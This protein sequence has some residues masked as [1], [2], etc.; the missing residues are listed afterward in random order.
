M[1]KS[2]SAVTVPLF[3]RYGDE[4]MPIGS[5]RVP[6]MIRDSTTPVMGEGHISIQ[7]LSLADRVKNTGLSIDKDYLRLA[8]RDVL[9]VPREDEEA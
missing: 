3:A 6:V 1:S 5:I 9:T 4:F 8:V 7:T 2:K